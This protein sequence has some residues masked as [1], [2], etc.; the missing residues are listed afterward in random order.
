VVAVEPPAVL[1]DLALRPGQR[2]DVAHLHHRLREVLEEEVDVVGVGLDERRGLGAP[3]QQHLVGAEQA[4]ADEEVL[5]VEVV[6]PGGADE[7]QREE[8]V[9]AAGAGAALP[10]VRSVG[11]VQRGVRHA[12]AR[13]VVQP[14]PEAGAAGEAD[15]VGTGERDDVDDIKA[16]APELG[17]N[18]GERVVGRRDVVVG[19]LDAG[20]QRVPPP[21]RHVPVRPA[22]E[23]GGV[24]GGEGEDVGAG[25]GAG[26]VGLEGDLDLVYHLEP[27]GGVAVG[28]GP[29]L[30]DDAAA[31]VQQQRGVASLHTHT[32]TQRN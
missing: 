25:D 2:R 26:A 28:V 17:D 18:G 11:R 9:V 10:Q 14:L 20:A 6:E 19:A 24:A 7:V 29:F 16:L 30:T 8:V 31:V 23:D 3:G 12:V 32:H 15:G 22:D 13:L 27:S 4:L 21:Q 5:E 1:P